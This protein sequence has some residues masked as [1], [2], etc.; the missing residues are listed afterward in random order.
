MAIVA[1]VDTQKTA[2]SFHKPVRIKSIHVTP[3]QHVKVGEL[4]LEAER[5]DLLYDIE[6]VENEKDLLVASRSKGKAYGVINN[7]TFQ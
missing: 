7:N 3:G 5:P 6:K 2:I 1:E 4:P